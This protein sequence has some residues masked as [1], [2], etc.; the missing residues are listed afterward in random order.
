MVDPATCEYTSPGSSWMTIVADNDVDVFLN[1][2]TTIMKY[3]D[4]SS[5]SIRVD[6]SLETCIIDIISKIKEIKS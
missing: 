1:I 2:H 5:N 4:I 3:I 6:I